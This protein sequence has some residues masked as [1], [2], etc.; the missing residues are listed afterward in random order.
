MKNKGFVF[1]VLGLIM[2]A[3]LSYGCE[4]GKV[5]Q[6]QSEVTQLN[7]VIQQK[8]AN[9]KT[10]NDQAALKEKELSDIRRELETVKSELEALKQ[11]VNV[12]APAPVQE[13]SPAPAP[14]PVQEPAPAQESTPAQEPAQAP[15]TTPGA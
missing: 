14:A 13:P 7:Q 4:M 2:G 15:A 9:I 11:K 12:P 1:I 10:L 5:K 8:D 3:F 6:L